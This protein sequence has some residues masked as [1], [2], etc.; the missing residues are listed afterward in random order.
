MLLNLLPVCTYK[1]TTLKA[2]CQV[3]H[4]SFIHLITN[5]TV[6]H[7]SYF[8]IGVKCNAAPPLAFNFSTNLSPDF[9]FL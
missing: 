9:I 5:R 2:V 6:I 1:Y 7:L 4:A 8:S 3:L